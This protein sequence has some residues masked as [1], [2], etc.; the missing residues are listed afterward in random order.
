MRPR[1][2][3]GSVFA[4]LLR[5]FDPD[6]EIAARRAAF[7]EPAIIGKLAE[8]HFLGSHPIIKAAIVR[9]AVL[10]PKEIGGGA[11][12]LGKFRISFHLMA[13]VTEALV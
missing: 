2:D 11:D 9:P 1:N 7:R 5:D 6:I 8:V 10:L 13:G 3:R 4:D 12:S